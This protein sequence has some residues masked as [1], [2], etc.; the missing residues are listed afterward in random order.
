MHGIEA[1]NLEADEW[2]CAGPYEYVHPSGWTITNYIIAAKPV[3]L[4]RQGGAER[5][6][7]ECVEQAKRRY[8]ERS[9]IA[10]TPQ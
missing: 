5:G 7:F 4:L 9:A 1:R 8:D 3:W 6:S 10:P 2:Q